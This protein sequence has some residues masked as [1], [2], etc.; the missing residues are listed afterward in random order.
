M[1]HPTIAL[2]SHITPDGDAIG[3][4]IGAYYLIKDNLGFEADMIL[5]DPIPSTYKFLAGAAQVKRT[6]DIPS[7]YIPD[8][9]I[10]LD[11]H[12]LHRLGAA[13]EIFAR[14]KITYRFDHHESGQSYEK[15]NLLCPKMSSTSELL[16]T[17][18]RRLKWKISVAA[19]TALYTGIYTDTGRF[20]FGSTPETFITAADLIRTGA[21]YQLVPINLGAIDKDLTLC[22]ANLARKIKFYLDG[23]LAICIAR[24]RDYEKFGVSYEELKGS[25]LMGMLGAVRG[26]KVEIILYELADGK[27]HVSMRGKNTPVRPIAESF[28]GGGHEFAASARTVTKSPIALANKLIKLFAAQGFAE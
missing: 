26:V 20:A 28:G 17:V 13:A 2:I 22:V 8:V 14:A 5:D 10:A 3:S 1:N 6:Q 18:A 4:L 11:I 24:K 21:E 9:A 7:D 23:K 27:W 16:A 25:P 15:G 12:A 19:A